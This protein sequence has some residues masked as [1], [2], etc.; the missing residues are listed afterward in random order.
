MNKN[1][2]YHVYFAG[3]IF[4][5]Q[6]LAGN[7]LLADAIHQ[8]SSG[9]YICRLPQNY[10][11]RE[12]TP[13]AIRDLDLKLV[14]SA[15]I[16]LFH[17]DGSELD[18]GTVIEFLVAKFLDIPSVVLR[19][20]FR[21]G[22]DQN[23]EM[24]KSDEDK[25]YPWNLMASWY[26]RTEVVVEN[27]ISR[28][29]SFLGSPSEDYVEVARLAVDASRKMAEELASRVTEAFDRVIALPPVLSSDQR[30]HVYEWAAHFP[31]KSFAAVFAETDLKD[32]LH[33]KVEK[34]LL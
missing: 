6:Q 24:S 28:F 30:E 2:P 8:V 17:F 11:Q 9:Q 15:D 14:M 20:D 23:M 25:R 7:A 5:C 18:V 16:G 31:G 26:P 13:T 34:G 1:S 33:S 27:A 22:G 29:Q 32:L 3:P 12:S 19:S 10:E 21:N 4:S